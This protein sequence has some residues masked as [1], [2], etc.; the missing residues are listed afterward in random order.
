ML[1]T[2]QIG[3]MKGEVEAKKSL[4]LFFVLEQHNESGTL[5]VIQP[6]MYN[7]DVL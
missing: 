3:G 5:V 6:V 4:L 2:G 7:K 1:T